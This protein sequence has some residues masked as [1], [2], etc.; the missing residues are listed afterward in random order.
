MYV[1][2]YTYTTIINQKRISVFETQKGTVY[3]QGGGRRKSWRENVIIISAKIKK[4][5][6][7]RYLLPSTVGVGEF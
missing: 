7:K 5:S 4:K 2:A 6:N 1:Y 3:G